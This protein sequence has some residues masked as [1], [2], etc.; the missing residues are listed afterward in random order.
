MADAPKKESQIPAGTGFSP[1]TVSLP[2]FLDALVE[3][4]GDRAAIVKAVNEVPVRLKAR[5]KTTPKT[6]SLPVE[7]AV[8][9][10]LLDG[11]TFEATALTRTL[12]ALNGDALYD[13]FARHILRDLGGLRVVQAMEEM[14]LDTIKI[15]GP[16]LSRYLTDQGFFVGE[17]NTGINSLRGWLAKAGL[18]PMKGGG[19]W[20]PDPAVKSRLV[21]L[22]DD[23]IASLAALTPAQ[24]AFTRALARLDPDGWVLATDV[25][26]LAEAAEGIRLSRSSLPKEV[27]DTLAEAGWIEYET[28]GTTSGKSSRLKTT[29]L[30]EADVVGPFLERTVKSL[31]PALAAYYRERPADIFAGLDS[32]NTHTKGQAL[33]A[34][35]VLVMRLLGLRF[36]GWR[37]R[38]HE[39]GGSEVDAQLAGLFGAVPTVWQ[40]QC[41]NTPRSRVRLEDVAKEVGLL[42][43]TRATHILV[44]ANAA[45]T[46]DARRYA[47]DIMLNTSVTI[48]LLDKDDVAAMRTNTA[49][50]APVLQRHAERIRDLKLSAPVWGEGDSRGGKG[51][52]SFYFPLSSTAPNRKA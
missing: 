12:A 40:V 39:T 19:L 30:F 22:D 2:R 44:L 26:D 52:P 34:F 17:Q 13:A 18:F 31:D 8:Q 23:Q 38:S 37:R 15:T 24:A 45:F 5:G 32:D 10:G 33:E 28:D 25:R 42:P 1:G 35:A 41:K 29:D 50:L 11:D 7:A 49:S 27:L 43:L 51:K 47:D 14:R 20:I 46:A 4:S 48:F 21:G 36:V 3:H 9:Y 6:L 16:S